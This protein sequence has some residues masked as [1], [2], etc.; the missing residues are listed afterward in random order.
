MLPCGLQSER[1]TQCDGRLPASCR[2]PSV[3]LQLPSMCL[4]HHCHRAGQSIKVCVRISDISPN[5]KFLPVA[6]GQPYYYHAATNQSTYV[7]PLPVPG[8]VTTIPHNAIIPGA[9]PK[10]KKE[11]PLV[12]TP[13]PDTPWLRVKTTEGNIFYTHREKK[14][15]VW[16]VPEE[17]KEQVEQ[18]ERDEKEKEERKAAE[19]LQRE[20]EEERQAEEEERRAEQEEIERI[21]QEVQRDVSSGK[22]KALDAAE[23]DRLTNKKKKV[24]AETHKGADDKQD[25]E[26]E[27]QQNISEETT[28]EAKQ[29]ETPELDPALGESKMVKAAFTVPDRVDLSLDEAKALFKV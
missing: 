2:I 10:K 24:S 9:V 28:L 16:Q 12:K 17:I 14:E 11:K 27:W 5:L 26:E 21:K 7:R 23:E 1:V 18:L 20:E 6:G 8:A 3:Q 29:D 15:S 13:I 25:S 19:K 4:C 22:R